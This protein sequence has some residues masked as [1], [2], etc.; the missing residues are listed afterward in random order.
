MASLV[1]L[2]AWESVIIEVMRQCSGGGRGR[3]T[4]RTS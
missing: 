3:H 2:G 1:K 4:G